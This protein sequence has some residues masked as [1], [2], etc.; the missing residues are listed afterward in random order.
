MTIFY[1]RAPS[2]E[3]RELLMPKGPLS[4]LAELNKR[5]IGGREFDVHFR[6]GDEVHVYHGGTRLLR[7]KRLKRPAGYVTLMASD[8]YKKQPCAERLFRRWRIDDPKLH[9]AAEVYLRDVKIGPRWTKGEGAI[10]MV[11]SRVREPWIPFDREAVLGNW[12]AMEVDQ[13]AVDS[14]GRLVLIELKDA[15]SSNVDQ[16][17]FQIREYL[18]KWYYALAG[19]LVLIGQVQALLDAR[20][21]MGLTPQGIPD[22]TGGLRGAVCFGADARSDEVKHR[23]GMVLDIVNDLLPPGVGPIETWAVTE[24]S[25]H[26]LA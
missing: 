20:V 21:K 11:W 19:N 1:D 14:D 23:Y 6:S 22:L 12:F 25:P 17:P 15:S 9:E 10:Q 26:Q 24:N 2:P 8:G 3:L 13:L 4:W 7:V 16:A 5:R 18:Q